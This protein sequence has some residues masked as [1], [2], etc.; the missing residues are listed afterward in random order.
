MCRFLF[1]PEGEFSTRLHLRA[2]RSAQECKLAL[3]DGFVVFDPHTMFAGR[4]EEA[5]EWFCT[6][7]FDAS[8]RM[9]G[10]KLLLLDEAWKYCTP[11]S[12]PMPLATCIQTGRKR[13]LGMAFATQRPNRLNESIT[14]ETTELV[15][16]RLQGEDALKRVAD[17]GADAD[18]VTQLPPGSFVAVNVDT[19]GVLR[20]QGVLGGVCLRLRPGLNAAEK[21][22]GFLGRNG[23]A[24]HRLPFFFQVPL[25]ECSGGNFVHE[26][27]KPR[28]VLLEHGQ[29]LAVLLFR[30]SV[31]DCFD[32]RFFHSDFKCCAGVRMRGLENIRSPLAKSFRFQVTSRS[33]C[34]ASASS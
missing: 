32:L 5:L 23:T 13:G 18:E 29:H 26:L 33:T 1:D 25:R 22:R 24:F 20:G 12:I 8:S 19:G 14:N 16:F 9:P 28:P 4:L 7:A 3:D 31:G 2:A 34:A 11:G 30:A 17:L 6:F 21:C 15:C 27:L 10:A